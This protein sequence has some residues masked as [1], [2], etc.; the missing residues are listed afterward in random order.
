MSGNIVKNYSKQNNNIQELENKLK[1]IFYD[2]CYDT[3]WDK[4]CPGIDKYLTDFKPHFQKLTNEGRIGIKFTNTWRPGMF[5][6]AV[7]DNTEQK[8][9][10]F[11][12][13]QL[14][15]ILDCFKE[16]KEL[17]RNKEWFKLIAEQKSTISE[18]GF[19]IE[20]EPDN[21][22]GLIILK[23][24]LDEF[25]SD[26]QIDHEAQRQLIRNEIINGINW[27]LNVTKFS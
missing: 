23:K 1:P 18:I 7:I 19:D 2:I 3:D 5:A 21:C 6:G 17:F 8:L 10:D 14:C 24:P 25:I 26:E 12:S 9:K 11:N 20:T 4:E 22:Y 27:I 16:K 13:P 15:V